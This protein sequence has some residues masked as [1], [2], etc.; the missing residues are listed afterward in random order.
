MGVSF[1]VALFILLGSTFFIF[2]SFKNKN[3]YW[4][5]IFAFFVGVF[6]L[7]VNNLNQAVFPYEKGDS[8][9][10]SGM[11]L[12]NSAWSVDKEGHYSFLLRADTINGKESDDI[13]YIYADDKQRIFYGEY[14]QIQGTAM[15]VQ[16]YAN[17]NAFDYED[18]L[19][20]NGISGS[21][22]AAF[23]GKIQKTGLRGGN[24]F[25]HFASLISLRFEKALS[26]LPQ[27]QQGLIKGVFLGEKGDLSDSDKRLLS[28]TG[29]MHAFSVSGLHVGYIIWFGMF[30]FGTSRKNRWW[31]LAII[32]FLIVF[33]AS[34]TGF[35]PPVIRASLMALI[36]LAA[37]SLDE[38]AD[39]YVSLA[40][41]CLACLLWR[42]LFIFDVGF[43]LS[44]IAVWGILYLTPVFSRM[45]PG[46][47]F[48]NKSFAVT[49]AASCA[50][51]P[52]VAYYF[53]ILSLA[54]MSISPI[55]VFFIGLV[56]ILSFIGCIFAV[57]SVALATLPLF[58]GGAM[59]DFIYNLARWIG[60][61]PFSYIPLTK[62]TIWMIV[63]FYIVL[64]AL[65]FILKK[66]GR[67]FVWIVIVLLMIF[68][69]FPLGSQVSRSDY[70]S[71]VPG[72]GQV[73]EVT[74]I[75]VG[76]GDSTLIV[77]P[78]GHNI[79]LDGGGKQNNKDWIGQKILLPYLQS[80]GIKKLDLIIAS[81]PHDDH[82]DGLLTVLEH[83]PTDTFMTTAVFEEVD[84]QKELEAEAQEAGAKIIYVI[85]GERYLV[86]EDLYL[87]VFSPDQVQKYDTETANEGS[88]V[89]KFSYKEIDF[90]FTGDVEG[91]N[92]KALADKDIGAEILKIP[93]H[94]SRNSFDSDFYQR[95]SP[96]AVVICVGEGNA[97]G[98]PA[99]DVVNYF[100]QQ[101]IPVY[102]TDKN[103]AI[104]FFSDGYS[105]EV[106]TID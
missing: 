105:L 3:F 18:Y 79:L 71:S 42:P 47:D 4:L 103:G 22:S 26:Y 29:I 66:K 40:L 98:H 13:L 101:S 78:Q 19:K 28:Q 72:N 15:Q 100:R 35:S 99:R 56:V 68:L 50:T 27:Q 45:L 90:L 43:Q 16:K 73:M 106:R 96:Q 39:P 21:V 2:W 80:R 46:K 83:L 63:L 69:V 30:I 1:R 93:H 38:K 49:L 102:Q 17:A 37:F 32:G 104:S 55:L 97:F 8:L 60:S 59:M 57:F 11:A 87:T 12:E 74:F 51:I 86:E 23:G 81:H 41:A 82:V 88:L 62:P 58:A 65:P 53:Y 44:F 14:V 94:G 67:R 85:A 24:S 64:L 31:R 84:L 48:I 36:G 91:N 25:L 5:L 9:H 77:T 76:Q 95:V 61:W 6:W 7:A 20:R 54:A 33:Y 70:F 10:I 52:L 92:L 75:D 89:A 34:I